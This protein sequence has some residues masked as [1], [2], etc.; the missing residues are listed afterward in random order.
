MKNET[1][2]LYEGQLSVSF[3]ILDFKEQGQVLIFCQFCQI[4]QLH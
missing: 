3:L 2:K 1:L 4:E